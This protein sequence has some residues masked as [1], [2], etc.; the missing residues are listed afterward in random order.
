MEDLRRL[1]AFVI[2]A[3]EMNLTRAAQRLHM[4]QPHHTR[5]LHHLEDDLGFPLFDRSNKRQL[6]L[7]PAGQTF[8]TQITPMLEQYEGAVQAAQRVAQGKGGKLIVG[9][10]PPAM[11]SNV[12]PEVLQ[13]YEPLPDAELVLRDFST[14]SYKGQVK[15]LREHHLDILFT[16]RPFDEPGIAHECVARTSLVVALP[17]SHR[18]R[19]LDAIPL[20]ALATERWIWPTFQVYPRVCQECVQLCQQAGF[21]PETVRV[22]PQGQTIVSLVAREVGVAIL[23]RWVQRGI[24]HQGVIYRPLL[25]VDYQLELHLLWRKND[26]SPLV[27]TFLQVEREEREKQGGVPRNHCETSVEP[28]SS[29]NRT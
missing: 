7:T 27:Q 4:V 1:R 25:D 17:A 19:Q 5:L 9:Y 16:V 15:A 21:E 2:I 24:Q 29:T 8:L 22:V 3:E 18:L 23:N 26:C 12:L 10:T 13:G 28:V 14:H 20:P 11:L 6:A